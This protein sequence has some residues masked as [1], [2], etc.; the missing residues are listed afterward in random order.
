[1]A[2]DQEVEEVA[3]QRQQK[4]WVEAAVAVDPCDVT[5]T[6]FSSTYFSS[7]RG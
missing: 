4:Y 2:V 6:Y 1:M 3:R 5:D 7:I